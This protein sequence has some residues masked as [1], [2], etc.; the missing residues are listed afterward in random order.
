MERLG[1]S[2]SRSEGDADLKAFCRIEGAIPKVEKRG[3]CTGRLGG[4]ESG[5]VTELV[6]RIQT[7]RTSTHKEINQK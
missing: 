5:W 3:R 6:P 2:G 1:W 4:Q 7:Q